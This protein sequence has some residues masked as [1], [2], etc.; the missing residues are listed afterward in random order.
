MAVPNGPINDPYFN[1]W[2]QGKFAVN[3]EGGMGLILRNAWN[4]PENIDTQLFYPQ[5]DVRF[6]IA[7]QP[8]HSANECCVKHIHPGSQFNGVER[9]LTKTTTLPVITTGGTMQFGSGLGQGMT[10]HFLMIKDGPLSD[11]ELIDQ[12]TQLKTKFGV[13]V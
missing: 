12:Y 13:T 6:V 10:L 11:A 5:A 7:V 2:T 4:D 3:F 9:V 8:M 1:L